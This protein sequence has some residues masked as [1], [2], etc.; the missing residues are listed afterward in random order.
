MNRPR[1]ICIRGGAP[2]TRVIDALT[3]ALIQTKTRPRCMIPS[4]GCPRTSRIDSGALAHSLIGH[5]DRNRIA[6]G[7]EPLLG[8]RRRG[9]WPTSST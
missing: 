9:T 8:R 2:A 4:V 6:I 3:W 1:I 5:E 7:L